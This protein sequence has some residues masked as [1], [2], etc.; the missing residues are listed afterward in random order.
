MSYIKNYKVLRVEPSKALLVPALTFMGCFILAGICIGQSENYPSLQT[1]ATGLAVVL[2]LAALAAVVYFFSKLVK[3]EVNFL[4]KF[5][6]HIK[7]DFKLKWPGIAEVLARRFAWDE[8][9]ITAE[10][11]KTF[12]GSQIPEKLPAAEL[13]RMTDILE[14]MFVASHRI[15]EGAVFCSKT[16]EHEIYIC[17]REMFRGSKTATG[18]ATCYIYDTHLSF[19]SFVLRSKG[20]AGKAVN[21]LSGI[22]SGLEKSYELSAPKPEEVKAFFDS[23]QLV[24]ELLAIKSKVTIEGKLNRLM[25]TVDRFYY[26]ETIGEIFAVFNDIHRIFTIHSQ[27]VA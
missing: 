12:E 26:A 25:I 7:F 19:P 1:V 11:E 23:P 8:R 14:K 16:S 18:K 13:K 9:D 22:S 20:L 3:S 6:R 10:L 15:D 5:A 4:E 24:K 17:N 2:V 21:L 27:K